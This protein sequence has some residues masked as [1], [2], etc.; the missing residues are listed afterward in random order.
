MR[1]ISMAL[2]TRSKWIIGSSQ[3]GW[4]LLVWSTAPVSRQRFQLL[5]FMRCSGHQSLS[6][7]VYFSGTMVKFT[8]SVE[9]PGITLSVSNKNTRDLAPFS[10]ADETKLLHSI[11]QYHSLVAKKGLSTPTNWNAQIRETETQVLIY[12]RHS[13]TYPDR[14]KRKQ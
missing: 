1:H 13:L 4:P 7:W 14:L 2:A 5:Q 11:L 6:R 9:T 8:A 3:L 12:C 10:E